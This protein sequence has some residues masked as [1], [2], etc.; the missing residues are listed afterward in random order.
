MSTP[1]SWSIEATARRLGHY[2]WVEQ[3]LFEVLGGLAAIGGRRGELRLACLAHARHH[4]WHA[5]LWRRRLPLLP[6]LGADVVVVAP[7][8][9]VASLLDGAA[10]PGS[11]PGAGL[12]GVYRV[13]LPQLVAVYRRHLASARRVADGPVMRA[14][15]LVLADEVRD[16]HEG[17]A[18]LASEVP[19]TAGAL[20]VPGPP[21]GPPGGRGG[22]G[23]PWHGWDT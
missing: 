18:L 14:L 2:A 21:E 11:D 6:G 9:S 19:G 1:P 17:E 5:E 3:R 10:Q 12:V 20:A 15:D 22:P 4:A 7:N 8:D 13:A 16:W 23:G